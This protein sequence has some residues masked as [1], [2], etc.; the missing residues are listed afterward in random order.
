MFIIYCLTTSV[1]AVTGQG[2]QTP[3]PGHIAQGSG[4]IPTQLHQFGDVWSD[5]SMVPDAPMPV[6]TN[7]IPFILLSAG[8]L[9]LLQDDEGQPEACA[10]VMRELCERALDRHEEDEDPAQG[11]EEEWPDIEL[12]LLL[13]LF[14]FFVYAVWHPCIA[15]L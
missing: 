12:L 7:V 9:L 15:S 1:T 8:V 14:F 3:C 10:K 2:L 13:L 6:M 11:I 4:L 5:E